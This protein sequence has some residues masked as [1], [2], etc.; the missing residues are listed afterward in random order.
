V[1]NPF[2]TQRSGGFEGMA[3]SRDGKHLYPLLEQTVIGDPVKTLRIYDFDLR[4]RSVRG[5]RAIYP[6][7]PGGTNIG[8]FQMVTDDT[9]LVIERDGSQG[10][11]TGFKRIFEIKIG[12]RGATAGKQLL[13]DL[14]N[15]R[16]PFQIS[17]PGR[18]GD[19]GLGT[20]FSFPF[21]TIEDVVV[22]GRRTIAV[23]NDNNFPFSL[24]RHIGTGAA[25][26][27]E[28]IV[29]DVGRDLF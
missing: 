5:V 8:D 23:L 17:L 18:P 20:T 24:G 6:L 13:V 4:S 25:D 11:V 22:V 7:D 10:D 27:D 9:G 16:D 28:I 15:I 2:R 26:D 12:A 3:L 14:Q 21:Q 1:S 29:I 19:V